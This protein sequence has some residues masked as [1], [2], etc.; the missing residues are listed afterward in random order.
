MGKNITLKLDEAVLKKARHA[1]VEREQSVSE[2]VGDLIAQ[3]TS[4][5]DRHDSA[6]KRALRRLKQG[7]HLGGKP[8]ERS[9]I[10]E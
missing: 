6:R 5:E 4:R 3:A 7:F 8:Q 9:E 1:A 10:Y 2:W